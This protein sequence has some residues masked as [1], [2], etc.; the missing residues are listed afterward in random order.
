[1]GLLSRLWRW[2]AGSD[3]GTTEA[4]DPDPEETDEPRLD[5]GNVTEVRT[6]ATDDPVEK[7]QRVRDE[8]ADAEEDSDE[9]MGDSTDS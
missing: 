3:D 7:L 2:I 6:S 1:M 8:G 5:P 9:N 4:V